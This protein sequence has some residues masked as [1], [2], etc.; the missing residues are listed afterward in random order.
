MPET[1][2]SHRREGGRLLPLRE[3]LA[4]RMRTDSS[5]WWISQT[6]NQLGQTLTGRK[7]YAEAEELLLKAQKDLLTRK[8]KIPGRF[9]RYIDEAGQALADLYD[10]WGKKEQAAEWQRRRTVSEAPR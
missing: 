9:H 4:L 1:G 6:K 8:D 3:C 7:R 2:E 10:A 5:D